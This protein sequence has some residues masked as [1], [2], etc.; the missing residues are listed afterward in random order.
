[1]NKKYFFS[2][3]LPVV[4][5]G[6]IIIILSSIPYL[7]A[8]SIGIKREDLVAHFVVYFIFGILL[9]RVVKIN[10]KNIIIS[11]LFAIIFGVI[12]ELNQIWIPRRS[13]ELLD[14]ISNTLGV[15]ASV[16]FKIRRKDYEKIH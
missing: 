15:L 4:S 11:I 12:N 3:W 16:I 10:Y 14:I 2:H 7:E 1:M 13:F 5:W 8:P 6:I 9:L